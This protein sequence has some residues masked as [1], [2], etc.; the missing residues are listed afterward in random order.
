MEKDNTTVTLPKSTKRKKTTA[1]IM[2]L[3]TAT[4]GRMIVREATMVALPKTVN[5]EADIH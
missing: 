1:T 5:E 2:I 3:K 4:M